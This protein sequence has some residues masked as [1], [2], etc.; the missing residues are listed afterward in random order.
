MAC[1]VVVETVRTADCSLSSVE[2]VLLCGVA[3]KPRLCEV[4]VKVVPRGKAV[5]S[6]NIGY[7]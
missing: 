4:E 6:E 3:V 2:I 1:R 7:L 5:G